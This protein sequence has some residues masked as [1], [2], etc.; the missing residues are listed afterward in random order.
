VG[1]GVLIGF[2]QL[3]GVE[4]MEWYSINKFVPPEGS[5]LIVRVVHIDG[6]E[7]YCTA[8]CYRIDDEY[9][10]SWEYFSEGMKEGTKEGEYKITHFCIPDA[11]EREE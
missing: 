1:F 8:K 9:T 11:V 4:G 5:W 3:G 6:W 10:D 2:Y 7:T